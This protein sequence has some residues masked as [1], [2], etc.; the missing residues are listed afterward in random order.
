MISAPL[1]VFART[2][3]GMGMSKRL[4]RG[5]R[6]KLVAL[7]L[8]FA[9]VPMVMVGT[10]VYLSFQEIKEQAASRFQD[11]A[12]TIAD[13]IDRNLFERYGDVQAFGLNRVVEERSV[14][15]Q[16]DSPIVQ[17]MDDYVATYGIYALTLL[18]DLDGR[19]I[20]VNRRDAAGKPIDSRELYRRNYADAPWFKALKAGRYTTR[21]AF[22]AP[23]NDVSSGTFIED[24]HVDKDVK[25]AYPGDDGLTLG[26]SAP[27]YQDGKVIA[28]WSN[29][30]RFA[31]VEEIVAQAYQGLRDNGYAGAEL[32]L[33]DGDGRVIVDYDP[34]RTGSTVVTHDLDT[35]LFK[36]N[37]VQAGVAAARAAV[38]GETGHQY[39]RHAR[40][41]IMQAAGYSHLHGALGYPGMNWSVMVRVPEAQ[42]APWLLPIQR[43]VFLIILACALFTVVVGMWLGKRVVAGIGRMVE[44]VVAA[45]QGDLAARIHNRSRDEFGRLAAAFNAMMERLTE[46]VDGVHRGAETIAAASAQIAHA[47]AELSVRTEEQASS[48]E[49]TASSME[50]MTSTVSQNAANA[51]QADRLAGSTRNAAEQGGEVVGQAA[52]AMAAIKDS[53]T[54]IAEIIAVIDE[55]AFQTNLLALNAAV[56][57]ARAGDQG[58]GFAVVAGEVRNLA[59]RSAGAAREIKA[60]IADSVEKVGHGSSLVEDSTVTLREIVA[61]VRQVTDIVAGISAASAEQASG[62]EQVNGAI[63]QMDQM[64]QQNAAMV[65]QAAAASKAMEE[66]AQQL[67]R[68]IAFFR[69]P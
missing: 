4:F 16:P 68:Q 66:Q 12:V 36:L 48:L 37:L 9:L 35:V 5:V 46:V 31:V 42:A 10:S 54:R 8:A 52:V 59:Q 47:N 51:A 33:L 69:L 1:G 29:R 6:A 17:I 39:A 15:Y 11:A 3:T 38:A 57:A 19:V 18:V 45:S 23:G 21:M 22:S 62:I 56:E 24:V 28:Y 44:A 63:M 27:V 20:A 2:D 30:A 26:F 43:N 55:I 7:L 25:R 67:R 65:E 50:E 60:L 34:T 53:S 32:T 14:W 41:G 58:R 61:G 40:K 49:E 13:K 64:T